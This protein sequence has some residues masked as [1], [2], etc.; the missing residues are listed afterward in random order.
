MKTS[1]SRVKSLLARQR[2]LTTPPVEGIRTPTLG[3]LLPELVLSIC[4][5]LLPVDLICFS[6]C[7]RRLRDLSLRQIATMLPC[8]EDD[9]IL[10]LNRLERDLP[11]YF[12]CEHCQ[13][14]HRYD[15]YQSFAFTESPQGI[16]CRLRC[17]REWWFTTRAT[18]GTHAAICY[19]ANH[20]S[21]LQLKLAMRRFRHGP[22]FG[23]STD[24]LF[25][26]QVRHA[27]P[28]A[29]HPNTIALFS[30]EALVCAEPPGLHIRM[31]DIALVDTIDDLIFDPDC[32]IETL[33]D[34]NPVQLWKICCHMLF[35]SFLREDLECFRTD[36]DVWFSYT[37][38]MCNLD[39]VYEIRE[40]DSQIAVIL[41]RWVNLGPGLTQKDPLWA[42]HVHH[43]SSSMRLDI[44][45]PEYPLTPEG[46]YHWFEKEASPR[47]YRELRFDNL[48]Y[49]KNHQYQNFMSFNEE[50]NIWHLSY[51]EPS[52]KGKVELFWSLL[53]RS[54]RPR[55]SMNKV[56]KPKAGSS[57]PRPSYLD[58]TSSDPGLLVMG[59][60]GMGMTAMGMA[61]M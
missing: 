45:N 38:Q 49:L 54:P 9:K 25:Y 39:C 20:L 10:I 24:S 59:M 22:K 3:G 31:Q 37:C 28:Q 18:L 36:G 52:K 6:L 41:T 32:Q 60:V 12:A 30:R 5:F 29:I 23:I 58:S 2:K 47:S 34:A 46:P 19:S 11:Q 35:T 17:V 53:G 40:F 43:P 27:P 7:S 8:T 16:T 26:T 33:D 48:G 61:M 21:F 55:N 1:K 50:L 42:N 56:R 14:L 44:D 4:D 15:G 51:E 57:Y 13:L